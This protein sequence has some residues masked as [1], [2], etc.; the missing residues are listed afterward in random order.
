M[1]QHTAGSFADPVSAMAQS[2]WLVE[3]QIEPIYNAHARIN[4]MIHHG[5][6]Q[7]RHPL[8][9]MLPAA[10]SLSSPPALGRLRAAGN[11]GAHRQGSARSPAVTQFTAL[12]LD[13]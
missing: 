11:A 13:D 5:Q 2:R 9:R 12:T 4:V 7:L 3:L 1:R 8:L 6:P 10:C